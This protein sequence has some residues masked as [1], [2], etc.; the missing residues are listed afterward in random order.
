[1]DSI[2]SYRRD[3]QS[4]IDVDQRKNI[5]T[6]QLEGA[7][8]IVDT[9]L[10]SVERLNVELQRLSNERD[11]RQNSLNFLNQ[12]TSILKASIEEYN[13]ILDN[14]NIKQEMTAQEILTIKEK[15]NIRKVNIPDG[16]FLWKIIDVREKRG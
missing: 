1:M 16:T 14:V 10:L 8:K 7:L 11:Q 13:T 12:Q 3:N 2:S 4:L 15:I 9:L 6:N 5:D